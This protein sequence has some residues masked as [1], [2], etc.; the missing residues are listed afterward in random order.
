MKAFQI[1]LGDG[2]LKK[3]VRPK[4]EEAPPFEEFAALLIPLAKLTEIGIR[5][6]KEPEEVVE[7]FMRVVEGFMK[8]MEEVGELE[9]GT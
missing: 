2:I 8:R 6:N 7:Y 9:E 5:N 1:R 3:G 4:F